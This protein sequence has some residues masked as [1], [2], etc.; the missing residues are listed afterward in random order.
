MTVTHTNLEYTT[1]FSADLA[2]HRYDIRSDLDLFR[3][4]ARYQEDP[5]ITDVINQIDQALVNIIHD[6][7]EALRRTSEED[8]PL[9]PS[10]HEYLEYMRTEAY[11]L[12]K[13]DEHDVAYDSGY[14]DGRDQG[15][16]DGYADGNVVGLDAGYEAGS[17]DAYEPAK[18]E[19]YADGLLDGAEYAR[20]QHEP[21]VAAAYEEG[22]RNADKRSFIE[23]RS[24]GLLTGYDEGHADGLQEG[25]DKGYKTCEDDRT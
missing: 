8:A 20:L 6:T 25:F 13:T 18:A 1:K 23:G 7:I 15:E 12:G 24:E 2:G 19:G 4:K 5:V 17:R 14:N 22:V 9:V 21:D 3:L 16:K 10:I 11:D